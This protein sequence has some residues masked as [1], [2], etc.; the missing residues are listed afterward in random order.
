MPS[1]TVGKH[2]TSAATPDFHAR[3]KAFTQDEIRLGTTTGSFTFKSVFV[4]D[5]LNTLDIS[6]SDLSVFVSPSCT[7]CQTRGKTIKQTIII[8]RVELLKKRYI[9]II[10][11]TTGT[12]RIIFKMGDNSEYARFEI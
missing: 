12:A 7:V 9:N 10:M 4:F 5:R 11:A 1:D 2:I 6:K 3:P 8:G